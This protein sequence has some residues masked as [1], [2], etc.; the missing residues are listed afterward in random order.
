MPPEATRVAESGIR[1]R[2]DVDR[3]EAAG[4]HAFLVGESLLR[5]RDRAAAVRA[6]TTETVQGA[7]RKPIEGTV[8]GAAAR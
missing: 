2:S 4:F 6:L 7:V 8:E 1:V 3:L 5:Q